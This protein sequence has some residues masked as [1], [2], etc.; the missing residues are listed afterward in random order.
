MQTDRLR[1]TK[2]TVNASFTDF[3]IEGCSCHMA[4]HRAWRSDE[5]SR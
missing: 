3:F 4:P 1:L 5:W 2:N